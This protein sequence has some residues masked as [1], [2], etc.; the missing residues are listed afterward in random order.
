MGRADGNH[1][2][3]IREDEILWYPLGFRDGN[4]AAA[5]VLYDSPNTIGW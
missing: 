3:E 1:S 4:L 2:K 5:V